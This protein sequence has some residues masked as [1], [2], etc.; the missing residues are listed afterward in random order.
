MSAP[1]TREWAQRMTASKVAA[2]LGVSKW[3]SPYSM[4]L[5]MKGLVPADDG[6]NANDKARGHYLEDGVVRW[7]IDQHP[8]VSVDA[9]QRIWVRA[10]FATRTL[11]LAST[12]GARSAARPWLHACISARR[13]P[14]G[15]A[16]QGRY[17]T[18]TKR[19][20]VHA[21]HCAN[22]NASPQDSRSAAPL[23]EGARYP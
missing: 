14:C 12:Q 13:D 23:R 6:R 10:S 1:G 17:Q 22:V 7:W 8:G 3:E 19:Y 9:T 16:W 4:W 20:C 15:D 18:V 11:C 21:M 2:V 5:R